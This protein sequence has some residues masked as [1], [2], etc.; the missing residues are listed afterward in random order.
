MKVLLNSDEVNI[1]V[2]RYLLE[3]GFIHTAFTFTNEANMVKNPSWLSHGD[4]VPPNGLV[5][6]L[7]KALLFSWVEYHTDDDTGE[8]ILCDQ[9]FSFFRRHECWY[10]G[11]GEADIGAQQQQQQQAINNEED[12]EESAAANTTTSTGAAPST[13]HQQAANC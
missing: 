8:E 7:Q 3:N 13:R 4:K 2:Y 10:H 12:K 5:A 6:F 9:P 1:L 11:D